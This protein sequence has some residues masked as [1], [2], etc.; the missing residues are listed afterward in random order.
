[1]EK[2]RL[3][4]DTV[5][6]FYDENMTHVTTPH[7]GAFIVTFVDMKRKLDKHPLPY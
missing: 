3:Q 2:E 5:I 1:M 4:E 6:C 7:A